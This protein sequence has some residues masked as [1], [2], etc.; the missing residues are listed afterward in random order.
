MTYSTRVTLFAGW[1][2]RLVWP[3]KANDTALPASAG[4]RLRLIRPTKANDTALPASAGW[5]LALSGLQRLMPPRCQL[6]PDG[7]FALCGL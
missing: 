4:W 3:T 6:L 5:R 2:L 7:G 1:R